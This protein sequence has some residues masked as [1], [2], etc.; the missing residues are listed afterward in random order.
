MFS[1]LL[2][3]RHI[4]QESANRG[5]RVVVYPTA[6]VNL[7]HIQFIIITTPILNNVPNWIP[8]TH[9]EILYIPDVTNTY[10]KNKNVK[11]C[12][13]YMFSIHL[14]GLNILLP[15]TSSALRLS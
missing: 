14:F 11:K 5:D 10:I 12:K 4:F 1:Y 3:F 13:F 15:A 8:N 7:F 9:N 6:N 2:L